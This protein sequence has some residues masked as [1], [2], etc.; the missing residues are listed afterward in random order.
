VAVTPR[1]R[2]EWTTDVG[3]LLAIEAQLTDVAAHVVDLAAG[4]N[5]PENARLMGHVEP[6]SKS[7]VLEHYA[8]LLDE[9]ARPF[10]L[11]LDGKLVGDADLRGLRDGAAEF[12]FMI[13]SRDQQGKG[14][15]TKFAI[16]LHAYAFGT[17]GLNRVYA[18]IVPK[19]HASRRVF[20][21]LG[22]TLDDS[23]EARAFAD[24][25]G[26]VTMVID[27]KTFERAHRA[28]LAQLSIAVR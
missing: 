18:S 25:A 4:Y 12:A 14:L 17:L 21:K 15:G 5:E 8:L 6:I 28:A 10:L 19:N 26:D 7:E 1:S 23:A 20:E 9:G 22:Y 2:I 27:R 13:A 3:T 24:E 16:M 11:C